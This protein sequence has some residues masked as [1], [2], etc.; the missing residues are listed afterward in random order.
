MKKTILLLLPAF[1]LVSCGS[2][3]RNVMKKVTYDKDNNVVST[4]EFTYQGNNLLTIKETDKE[5]TSLLSVSYN[6]KGL[7]T[8]QKIQ[9]LKDGKYVDKYL[10]VFTYDNHDVMLSTEDYVF[11]S[12]TNKYVI[13]DLTLY[14]FDNKGN[15]TRIRSIT[16]NDDLSVY[17][18]LQGLSEYNDQGMIVLNEQYMY[19]FDLETM[20]YFSGDIYTYDNDGKTLLKVTTLDEDKEPM[21]ISVNHYN[22]DKTL[23]EVVTTKIVG[24]IEQPFK[25]ETY[26][27]NTNKDVTMKKTVYSVNGFGDEVIRYEYD[28]NNRM[29]KESFFDLVGDSEVLDSYYV[30]SY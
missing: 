22:E 7:E 19:D 26:E 12:D 20:V 4:S 21:M 2:V 1:L 30:Y 11:D 17:M 24:G 3:N 16:Y 14:E 29:T 6:S 9:V 28:N 13:T 5:E 25:V 15:E 8:D 18:Q 23:K 10:T 27:Y